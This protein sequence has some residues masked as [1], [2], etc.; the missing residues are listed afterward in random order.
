MT[1]S[2]EAAVQKGC[3]CKKI[4][5]ITRREALVYVKR[6]YGLRAYHCAAGDVWHLT[7]KPNGPP[8]KRYD[9][10]DG[11]DAARERVRNKKKIRK[12]NRVDRLPVV[13]SGAVP[14]PKAPRATGCGSCGR[15][16]LSDLN[17]QGRCCPA[18]G[19]KIRLGGDAKDRFG[20]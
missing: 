9:R 18:C 7:S 12:A 1:V 13:V 4:A 3:D 20:L 19:G 5:Y 14:Q 16:W 2:L 6:G 17:P 8:K 11:P 10:F 15:L